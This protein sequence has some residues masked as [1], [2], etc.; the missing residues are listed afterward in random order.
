[1][2]RSILSNAL[3]GLL[4]VAIVIGAF[5]SFQRKRSSFERI[6][7]RFE[8][9][10]G[11]IA[12]KSV[13]PGSRAERAGLRPGDQIWLIGET[14]S[15]EI[16]GLQK[17]LRRI[18]QRVPMLVARGGRTMTLTYEVPELKIDYSYLILSF[19]GFLYLTIGLFTLFRGET[20]E[21]SIFYFVMLLSFTVYVYTPAGDID[22]IYKVLQIVEEIATIVL[23]PLALH[24][25]L[26]FPKPVLKNKR[27]IGRGKRRK[28][29]SV[30][31]GRTIIAKSSTSCSIL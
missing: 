26:L 10:N 13:D 4:T 11:V 15:T 17:T 14:P 23:P 28:K 19:I 31:G 8:R 9:V 27:T 3:I 16:D 21:S 20:K 30:S 7:F 25:F 12:V 18:G 29:F 2:R 5:A 6:D 22:T 1:M 24:F